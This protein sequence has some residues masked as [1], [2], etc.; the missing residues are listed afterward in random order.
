[1]DLWWPGWHHHHGGNVQFITAPDGRPLWLSPVRPGREHETTAL[2]R[3]DI[4]SLLTARTDDDLRVPPSR[5][6]ATS[7]SVL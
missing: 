3:D 2:R 1:V 5:P 7:A 6:S 4:L